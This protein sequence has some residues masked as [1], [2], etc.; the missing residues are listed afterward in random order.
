MT[1][2]Q[3]NPV[4]VPAAPTA[5]LWGPPAKPGTGTLAAKP[6]MAPIG[7]LVADGS[8]PYDPRY[9]LPHHNP[10]PAPAAAAVKPV[11]VATTW[12]IKTPMELTDANT[13][14]TIA[15]GAYADTSNTVW[16]RVTVPG[17][18]I[19]GVAAS[20]PGVVPAIAAVGAVVVA[21]KTSTIAFQR[22]GEVFKMTAHP[23]SIVLPPPAVGTVVEVAP[24]APAGAPAAFPSASGGAA[25]LGLFGAPLPERDTSGGLYPKRDTVHR[26]W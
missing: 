21:P 18:T 13:G 23:T 6:A 8:R 16:M 26:S 20:A 11:L 9:D 24:T 15:F 4:P 1:E 19:P 10:N 22:D 7:P 5:S 2:M 25:P 12:A 17:Y 14:V 3:A